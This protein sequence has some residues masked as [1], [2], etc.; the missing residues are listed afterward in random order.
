MVIIRPTDEFIADFRAKH[1]L[2]N[3]SNVEVENHADMRGAIE[4]E[5]QTMCADFRGYERPQAFAV[6]LEEFSIQSGLLTPAL[7]I[8][9][10]EIEKRFADVIASLYS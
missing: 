7:K 6:T 8:K 4:K 1:G 3:A 5:I 2:E 10:R 9:R